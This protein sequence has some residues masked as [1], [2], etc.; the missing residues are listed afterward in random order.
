MIPIYIFCDSTPVPFF[1]T[2]DY[3]VIHSLLIFISSCKYNKY[4]HSNQT[5]GVVGK[6]IRNIWHTPI[7]NPQNIIPACLKLVHLIQNIFHHMFLP[8]YHIRGEY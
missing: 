6:K 4:S 2:G 5:A 8:I 3:L 7:T 1:V